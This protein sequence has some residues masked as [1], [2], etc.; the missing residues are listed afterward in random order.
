VKREHIEKLIGGYAAGILTSE[1]QRALFE[2]ALQD[3][4][5]FDELMR[6]ESLRALLARPAARRELCSA[7]EPAPVRPR[8]WQWWP[9]PAAALAATMV[10]A[11]VIY[12]EPAP[13][14]IQMAKLR[15]ET[16]PEAPVA[17]PPREVVRPKA[18]V[19]PSPANPE[20]PG[21]QPQATQS[22]KTQAAPPALRAE[23]VAGDRPIAAFSVPPPQFAE[24]RTMMRSMRA[25]EQQSLPA[26]AAAQPAA[27]PARDLYY[28]PSPSQL[29]LRYV[30]E[31]GFLVIEANSAGRLRIFEDG[32]L[33]FDRVIG[34]RV[35]YR[36]PVRPSGSTLR[37]SLDRGEPAQQVT[38]IVELVDTATDRATYAAAPPGAASLALTVR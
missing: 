16:A 4:A 22:E 10:V 36:V 18:R 27:G 29:G 9:A 30:L 28:A 17:A 8:L 32:A 25:G 35:R 34:P 20:P 33:I 23:A 13:P 7:L 12:R 24:T 19:A 6:E 26:D 15:L 37:V 1:E 5:L 3:Q 14:P 21:P 31:N 38:P 2:A 11:M